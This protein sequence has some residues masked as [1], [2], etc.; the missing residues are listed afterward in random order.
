MPGNHAFLSPS[1]SVRWYFCPPS[2][3]LCEQ[4]P[5]QGSV[6]ASEGT[7]AHA[8]CEYL[9]KT[10]LGM[11]CGDPR[12][13]L[14][15]YSAEMEE[16]AAGYAQY[17][18][19]KV[20]RYKAAGTGRPSVFVEQLLDL[21]AYIPESMGTADCVIVCGDT[22]E[23]IDFKYGMHRVPAT[24]TQ[25]RI[26]A[27]GACE[28]FSGLYDITR[29]KMAIYQPRLSSVDE[30]EM[31]AA[32][33]YAWA[34]DE[35]APRARQAFDGTGEFACGEWCRTCRAR[36]NCRALAEYQLEIARYDFKDPAL[37]SDDE[38]ADVLSRADTLAAWASEV[39][40]YALKEALR[41]HTYP[42]YKVVAGRT[43]RRFTDDAEA[44]SRV[45]RAGKDP[46]E[47][48]LLGVNAMEKMLGRKAFSELLSDLV[49]RPEG[50]PVLVP[51]T[52]KRPELKTAEQ[53]FAGEKESE[54]EREEEND[55]P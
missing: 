14:K 45:E 31:S 51:V 8:L 53:D 4:F 21:R 22:A 29:V 50:K 52:D 1:S 37:L 10:A 27:L 39:K 7:D 15:Y 23:V 12:P 32:D 30:T 44:A 43:T 13:S 46:W 28:V 6:Y 49:A 34:R 19:E 9:L 24:S 33:L 26:Y 5:D 11:N 18:M 16:V 42:G 35:L 38:I 25:L 48:R 41:G 54:K 20:E 55:E 3:H 36:R 2:A 17:V 40:D 47:L